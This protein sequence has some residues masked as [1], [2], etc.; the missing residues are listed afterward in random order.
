[1][2]SKYAHLKG[3]VPERQTARDAALIAELEAIERQ[4]LAELTEGYNAAVQEAE[5]L[6]AKVKKVSVRLEA[7]EILI[8][9]GLDGQD[10]D[11]VRMN[12]FTWSSK[13][14]PY[15]VTE[16][17]SAVVRYFKENGLED[18][19][20]L[21]ASE[22]NGRLKNFVKEEALNNELL[23]GEKEV[24][25]DLTGETRQVTEVRSKIPGVRV[26]L[27]GGLSRVKSS[28]KRE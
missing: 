16:D 26:F 28:N 25:D 9:Q 14:E 23:V 6:A 12:G 10:A 20:E 5:E 27:K 15:P 3:R 21:S 2:A 1:M 22:L 8:R 11:A 7:R 24:V 13:F 18:Q 4:P 19:L 17:P